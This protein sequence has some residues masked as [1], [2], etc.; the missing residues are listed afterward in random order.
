MG[1]FHV[2]LILQKKPTKI[3]LAPKKF[4]G[5]FFCKSSSSSPWTSLGTKLLSVGFFCKI[6]NLHTHRDFLN[7]KELHE[8]FPCELDFVEKNLP[9]FS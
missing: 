6:S 4:D 8:F 3:L 1:S 9:S 2:S 7:A 5:I